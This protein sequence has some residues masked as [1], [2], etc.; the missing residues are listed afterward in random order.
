MPSLHD[1][2]GIA[3]RDNDRRAV[4]CNVGDACEE[5]DPGEPRDPALKPSDKSPD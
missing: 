5:G 2:I 3:R 1:I 4:R